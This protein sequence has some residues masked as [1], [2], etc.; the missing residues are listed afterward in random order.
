MREQDAKKGE[1]ETGR[2]RE[3]EKSSAKI[4]DKSFRTKKNTKAKYI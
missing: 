3:N 1:R 4:E 2:Q